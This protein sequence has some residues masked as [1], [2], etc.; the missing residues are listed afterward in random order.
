MFY[1]FFDNILRKSIACDKIKRRIV[2]EDFFWDGH[3]QKLVALFFHRLRILKASNS[4]QSTV[5]DKYWQ[6]IRY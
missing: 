1:L 2:H 6:F 3:M 5:N 4:D